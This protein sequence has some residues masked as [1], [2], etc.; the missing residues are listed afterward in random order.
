MCSNRWQWRRHQD[1]ISC[2][3][4]EEIWLICFALIRSI[5]SVSLLDWTNFSVVLRYEIPV[6]R[7]FPSQFPCRYTRWNRSTLPLRLRASRRWSRASELGCSSRWSRSR[8]ITPTRP[9]NTSRFRASRPVCET[10]PILYKVYQSLRWNAA[11]HCCRGR[12]GRLLA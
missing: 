8:K 5:M 11:S 10:V 1:K 3:D 6:L 7:C 9:R 4:Q 2:F 12:S